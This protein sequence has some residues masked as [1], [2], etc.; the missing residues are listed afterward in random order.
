VTELGRSTGEHTAT[1]VGRTAASL[2]VSW[3]A[4][5]DTGLRR[6]HNEDS[7]LAESPIF[8]VADG[9]GGHAAGDVAS[10]AVVRRLAEHTGTDFTDTDAIVE[11]LRAATA[12]ISHAVDEEHLGVGTTVT[13]AA[14]T[15]Q[16]GAAYWA[17]FN[18]G[19][20]RVY[21]FEDGELTRVTVDHSVVQELVDAGAISAKD[22]ESHPD[23]NIITRA[24]GFDEEPMPDY[25]M[26]PVRPGLRLLLCS[27]GLT[28]EV[29]DDRLQEQLGA[30]RTPGETVQDLVS[31]ALAAGGRD[32]VTAVIV[33]VLSP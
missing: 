24:I 32:N 31:A 18:V 15:L 9:M 12:D 1:L 6:D 16:E 2:T 20:S 25:W 10:A 13:G 3:A 19:D 26:L 4:L 30:G 14:L 21:M 33:D 5:T 17:I 11:A 22:A 7:L 29:P 8:A 23:S 27:D 28:K